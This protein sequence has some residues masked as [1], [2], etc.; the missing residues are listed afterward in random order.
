MPTIPQRIASAFAVLCGRYGD[1][2]GMAKDRDQSRQ[3]LYREAEK[4]VE[5]VE[6]TAAEARVE[7]LRRRLADQE[8]ENR[9]L[10]TRL[11][12]AVEM[13]RDK[14]EQFATVAQAEG[15]SLSVA[16][17]LLQVV[18]G[19]KPVPG[20]ATLGRAT[21]EAGR[22]AGALLEVL[23]EATRPRVEQAAADEIFWTQP[24]P[25]GGRAREPLLDH[26][27]DGRARDGATWAG[28]F[29]RLPA[30]KA[31]VRDDGTGLGKGVRLENARRHAAG[32]PELDQTL[33]VFHTLREGG[34]ALR[35]TWGGEPG[36]GACRRGPA[37][38][39]ATWPSGPIAS[40]PRRPAEPAVASGRASLGSGHGRRGGLG[41][42]GRAFELF[43]PEGRLNDHAHAEAVVA[44]A[45]PGLN[46]AAWAKTRRWLMRCESFTFLD[47]IGERLAG[48]GLAPDVLSALLDLEGLRRQPSRLSA[49]TR[50][51]ALARVVELSK[52]CPDGPEQAG[53][54]RAVL[55]GAWRAS[56]LV[57][58]V[59]SVGG[60]SRRGT[61]R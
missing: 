7:E 55:R 13:T 61:A 23:D 26:R 38:V 15:V 34:R 28:E 54:V 27:P 47:Q 46:G 35:K 59:N 36:P 52:S 25:D 31:V 5:A 8:A 53:R 33:D 42:P 19:S 44:T 20:V 39:R 18:A 17:R 24:G 51:W 57:E 56:S 48:L 14:Q 1:I 29:A 58:C 50:A 10:R 6:G 49:A 60:C 30:L 22:Q 21:L 11:E 12:R 4:V 2:A 41:S 32:L 43:T 16:R 45:L 9:V 37:G 40:G 3:S